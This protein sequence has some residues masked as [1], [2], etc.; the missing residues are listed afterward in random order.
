MYSKN[1]SKINF[2]DKLSTYSC[3]NH[4]YKFK[5]THVIGVL[6][7]MDHNDITT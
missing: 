4:N 6:A 3:N 1:N 7:A 2:R 5:C